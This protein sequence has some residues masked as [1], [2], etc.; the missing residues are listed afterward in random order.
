[1]R[2]IMVT[3]DDGIGS[4]GLI[5][6]VKAAKVF[7]EVYV[8]APDGQRSAASH[9]ITLHDEM[10][11]YPYEYPIEGVKAFTCSGT[12]ADCVRVGS[13][14]LM[15]RKPDVVLSG[16]NHG[17]NVATDIQYSATVGA[18]FEAAFQGYHAIALSEG[19]EPCHEVT[20]FYL[21]QLLEE[22]MEKSL[23]YGQILNVNFPDCP[24]SAC[25]GVLYDRTVSRGIPYQD[26]YVEKGKLPNG[27]IRLMVEGDISLES[28]EGSDYRAI[29]ENY[30]SVGVVNNIM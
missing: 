11:I 7:G 17:Y 18:A 12:P 27:G 20:D 14:N 6:L 26:H 24:L 10:I 3:N 29:L 22:L 1:M 8:V 15:D 16:V 28:E 9:S 25:K 5:R 23:Q 30:V 13:L 4:D 19:M 2:K 21:Q